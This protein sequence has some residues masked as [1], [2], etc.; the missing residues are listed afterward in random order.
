MKCIISCAKFISSYIFCHIGPTEWKNCCKKVEEIENAYR[1]T[2]VAVDEELE[3]IIINLNISLDTDGVESEYSSAE[4]T[5]ISSE[6]EAC[7]QLGSS[8]GV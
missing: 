4:T 2:E 5:E 3:K 8:A 7:L 1:Q 6:T